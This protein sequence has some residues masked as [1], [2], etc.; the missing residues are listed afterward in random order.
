MSLF[1]L[2]VMLVGGQVDHFGDK[3][4]QR[5]YTQAECRAEADSEMRSIYVKIATCVPVKP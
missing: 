5:P 3:P 1:I 4:G 2:Y